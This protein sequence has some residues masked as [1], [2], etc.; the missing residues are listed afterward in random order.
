MPPSRRRRGGDAQ[1]KKRSRSATLPGGT[2]IILLVLPLRTPTIE[3]ATPE[4]TQVPAQRYDVIRRLKT[5]LGFLAFVT[6][7]YRLRFRRKA[8]IVLFH[9]IDDRYP[10]DPI[11][12]SVEKLID[13][14]RS[15]GATSRWSRSRYWSTRSAAAR[16]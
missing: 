5:A 2:P 12:C 9:R 7:A 3:I 14:A 13:S 8:V 11:S 4:P 6:G 15:F 16:T 1:T 10:T